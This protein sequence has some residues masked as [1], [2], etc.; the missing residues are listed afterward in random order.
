MTTRSSSRSSRPIWRISRSAT[1]AGPRIVQRPAGQSARSRR[2]SSKAATSWAALA[3]ADARHRGQLLLGRPGEPGEAIV[4]RQRVGGEVDGR[5]SAR[6]GSPD[7]PDEL[8]RG[9]AAGAAQ[10]QPLARPLGEWDLADG[11][12]GRRRRVEARFAANGPRLASTVGQAAVRRPRARTTG[13]RRFPPPSGPRGRRRA[14]GRAL[15][16]GSTGRASRLTGAADAPAPAR[17]AASGQIERLATSA[18]TSR[19]RLNV[20][21]RPNDDQTVPRRANSQP[22]ASAIGSRV[23]NPTTASPNASPSGRAGDRQDVG[24]REQERRSDQA[25]ADP[26]AADPGRRGEPAEQDLLAER[27]DERRPRSARARTRPPCRSAAAGSPG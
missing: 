20:A 10:G 12:T 4:R 22:S 16:G 23:T 8:G 2:P 14:Y 17:R 5:P 11:A 7:Q 13:A 18:M 9:Q 25:A 6:P 3:D 26:E 1:S 21:C 19:T 15:T 27:R 24:H